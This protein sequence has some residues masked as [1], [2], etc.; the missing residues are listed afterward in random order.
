MPEHNNESLERKLKDLETRNSQLESEIDY[1]E[2]RYSKIASSSSTEDSDEI[3][4][5]ELWRAIWQGKWVIIAVTTVFAIG[6]VVYALSLPNEYKSTAILAPASQGSSA[7]GL[8]KLAGQFGGLASL[9]GINLGGAGGEDKVS[10]A[11]EIIKTWGFLEDFIDKNNIAPQ[12]FAAKGWRRE[13]NSI[14]YDKDIY[15]PVNNKW[16]NKLDE[17]EGKSAKPSGWELYE[18]FK[19]RVSITQ[20]KKSG[21]VKLSVEYYSPLL[22]KE[23]TDKL[24]YSINAHIQNQDRKE[25]LKNIEYLNKKIQE[26][27]IA[28]M[29]SVFYQLI[30]EQTKTLM[31]AEVSDEYVFK[32]LSYSKV[33]EVKSKPKRALI[34]VLGVILS[35][36]LAVFIV[37][38][39][40]FRN[41]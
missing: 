8:A 40:Y 17:N 14:I 39:R 12:V 34:I 33:A 30:E 19:D 11:M 24:V 23:W 20:D 27:N 25:A 6:S 7:G 3:D 38:I 13:S 26:T 28:G 29:Q 1:L 15:D 16:L 22:A 32:V 18:E 35:G 5:R 9:A 37:L 31:L 4:L 41:S 2:S 10:I 21:L 36:M